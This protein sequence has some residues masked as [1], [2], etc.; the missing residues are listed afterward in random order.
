MPFHPR[1]MGNLRAGGECGRPTFPWHVSRETFVDDAGAGHPFGSHEPVRARPH[2][3]GHLLVGVRERQPFGH[4]ARH[5]CRR[6]PQRVRQQREWLFQPEANAVVV[7]GG[8]LIG[9]GHQSLPERVLR[10]ISTDRRHA[11]AGEHRCAVMEHQAWAQGQGPAAAVVL[12]AVPCQ[13]LRLHLVCGI[14]AIERVPDHVA[15]VA[16][17]GGSGEHGIQDRQIAFRHDLQRIEALRPRDKWGAHCAGKDVPA[18]DQWN[19]RPPS[20]GSAMPVMNDDSSEVRNRIA[21][22]SSSGWPC[23][24]RA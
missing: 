9:H 6:F 14:H 20:T 2:H 3:L 22:A 16:H 13:H 19:V 1:E 18:A 4:Y 5:G 11:V 8:Q 17:H 23:R 21:A 15:V 24:P 12:G 10:A 7:Q